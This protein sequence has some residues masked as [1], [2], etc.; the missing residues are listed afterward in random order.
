MNS[1]QSSL[2]LDTLLR[3]IAATAP[4]SPNISHNEYV[5]LLNNYVREQH[6]YHQNVERMLE[7]LEPPTL[8]IDLTST[9][10]PR[11][12]S[13]NFSRTVDVSG[14]TITYPYATLNG[15]PAVC[16]ITLE[17]FIDGET[18]RRINGCGHVFRDAA[19]LRWFQRN[20]NCPVCRRNL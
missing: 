10:F 19:L 1:R 15:E 20:S 5:S 14:N 12:L 4:S 18:V 11:D 2:F 7:L 3:G 6:L 16:P 9:L 17:P 8:N 13:G